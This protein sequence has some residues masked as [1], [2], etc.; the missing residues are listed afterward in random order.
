MLTACLLETETGSEEILVFLRHTVG[1]TFVPLTVS[2]EAD[3]AAC[4]LT[5]LPDQTG[6]PPT[7]ACL[8]Y[9]YFIQYH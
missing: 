4:H 2:Q 1:R 8:D 6:E 3:S 9:F 7:A 5:G